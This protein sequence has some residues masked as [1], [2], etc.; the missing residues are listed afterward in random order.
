MMADNKTIAFWCEKANDAGNTSA[1]FHVNLWHFSN[2]K[3]SDFFE[4]GIMPDDP[5]VLTS[6][7]VYV[8]FSIERADIQ[9]LGPKFASIEIAQGIFNE[10]LSSAQAPGGKCVELRDGGTVYCQVHIF[11]LMEL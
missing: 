10:T 8:P 7:R 5:G 11:P 2:K 3:H 9:D 1:E 4:I 6:I